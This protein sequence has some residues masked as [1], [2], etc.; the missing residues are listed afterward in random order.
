MARVK[1]GTKMAHFSMINDGVTSAWVTN[2]YNQLLDTRLDVQDDLLT[3]D[4]LDLQTENSL[5][6]ELQDQ[7]TSLEI[8]TIPFV[9]DE[10]KVVDEDLP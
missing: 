7:T 9:A 8:T 5:T 2:H 4:S 1:T 10:N 3:E 6:I